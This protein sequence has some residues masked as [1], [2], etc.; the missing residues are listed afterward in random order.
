MNTYGVKNE[1][2]INQ[3]IIYK[4]KMKIT[5]ISEYFVKTILY[6]ILTILV[7]IFL[8]VIVSTFMITPPTD[9]TSL[10]GLP[11]IGS[12]YYPALF[13]YLHILC[14]SIAMLA[15]LVQI[16]SIFR[17]KIMVVHRLFGNI[18][19]ISSMLVCIFGNLYI[20]CFGTVGGINMSIAFSIAGWILGSFALITLIY[21]RSHNHHKHRNWA[22]RTFAMIYSSLFYRVCYFTLYFLFNYQVNSPE[23][24]SRP[25]DEFLDWFFFLFPLFC[26]ECFVRTTNYFKQKKYSPLNNQNIDIPEVVY[27]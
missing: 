17:K 26:A 18:A 6:L 20:Y 2:S 14:G 9:W 21:A 11:E 1:I 13:M 12:L 16:L 22:L 27:S 24:F 5:I 4:N 19:C 3:V 10:T 25:L 7:S 23:D 15:G 8:Y